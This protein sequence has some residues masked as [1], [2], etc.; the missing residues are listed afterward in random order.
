VV[1]S[2]NVDLTLRASRLPRPGETLAGTSFRLGFGGKGANQAVMAAKLGAAVVMVS[3]IGRDVF[4]EQTIR[5]YDEHGI[6]RTFLLTDPIEPTG[7]AAIIVDDDARNCI[8]VIPG[9]NQALGPAD[10]RAAALAIQSARV[11]LCQ[12]EIPVETALEAFRLA[13]A[14]GVRTVLNPA[15]AQRLPAEL[16]RLTDLCVPNETEI[17]LLTGQEVTTPQQAESAAR[18]LLGFGPQTVIVTLGERGAVVVDGAR[19]DHVPAFPVKAVDPTGAGDVFIASVAVFLAEGVPLADAVH[20]ASAAAALTVT[21]LGTQTAFP[22]RAE[23]EALL[24]N[25]LSARS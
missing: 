24:S 16:L 2:S 21:R 6:D 14:A 17:E 8:L 15:P 13:R 12:L 11:V 19:V 18:T 4:G 20:R 23:I 10:V 25:D 22:T 9:A 3:R 7:L 5:N 1:G